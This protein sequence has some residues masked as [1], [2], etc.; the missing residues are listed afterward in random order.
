MF[1]KLFKQ[2]SLTNT[3]SFFTGHRTRA[4]LFTAVWTDIHS[5]TLLKAP[6]ISAATPLVCHDICSIIQPVWD[7]F[8]VVFT[9]QLDQGFSTFLPL[10]ILNHKTINPNPQVSWQSH[11]FHIVASQQHKNRKNLHRFFNRHAFSS[12][13]GY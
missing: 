1:C 12:S 13:I 9:Q 2:H 10:S 8:W 5:Y 7:S 6:R 3:K 11:R 4:I